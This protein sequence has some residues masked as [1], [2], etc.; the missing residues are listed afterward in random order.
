[1]NK[2]ININFIDGVFIE[3]IENTTLHYEIEF[4][5][6]DTD[7]V[8]FALDLISN[9]WVN[10]PIKYF[11][12]WLIKIKGIDN[13]FYYEH[14]FDLNK[15]IVFVCIESQ[16]LGDTLAWIAYIEKFRIEKNCEMI[17]STYYNELFETE[18]PQIKFILP[19]KNII[20]VY[21]L[22]KLGFWYTIDGKINTNRHRINPKNLSL[23]Q[24]GSDILGIK[25]KELKPNLSK[26][27]KHKKKL[28]TIGF[29]ANGQFKYW[30]N[31]TGW[32]EVVDYLKSKGYEVR[33]VSNEEDGY[34]GNTLP[35]GVTK[36][37]SGTLTELIKVLQEST[38]FIGISSGLSWLAWAVETPTILISGHTDINFEPVN[39]VT[40]IINKEV[41][42]SCWSK[43]D[44]E[45]N[46]WFW[47]PVNKGT[48]KRFEC[49][50]TITGDFVIKHIK[51]YLHN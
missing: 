21:A 10:C 28:I 29:H 9:R 23:M 18:Y 31:P 6:K 34:M 30:N 48:E 38:L 46:N 5:D 17:C 1:M 44:F 51:P 15:K 36:Q 41:C 32:Q 16:S 4:I 12:N 49:T 26:L 35:S 22:Y 3:I 25:Y 40:R 50:K 24:V 20:D 19:K 39:G 8:I 33:V 27:G 45:H 13:D 37:P 42:N 2:K 14:I 7:T 47:C 11:V 43:Y